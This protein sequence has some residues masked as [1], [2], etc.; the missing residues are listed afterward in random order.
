MSSRNLQDLHPKLLP[1]A[2]SLE[3]ECSL[4]DIELLIY[5]TYRSA[6]EQNELYEIGRTKPG[7]KVTWLKGGASKHNFTVRNQAASLAFDAVPMK[8][9]RPIWSIDKNSLE[10][11]QRISTIAKKLGLTWGGDW[12]NK[13]DRPHFEISL[14]EK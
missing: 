10:L 14:N 6:A 1:I 8:N 2:R 9:G 7:K 5:C 12:P 3:F 11:W 4:I 13:V